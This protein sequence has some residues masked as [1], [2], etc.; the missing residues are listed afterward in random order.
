M[1]KSKL[2]KE[3]LLSTLVT[4]FGQAKSIVFASQDGLTV[5]ASQDLRKKAKAEGVEMMAVKKTILQMALNK[6]G[7]TGADISAMSG[8]LAVAVSDKDEVAPAKVIK[9][10]AKTNEKVA[11]RGGFMNGAVL[12]LVEVQKI[13]DLPSKQELLAK[14]VGSLNAPVAGF[15][16]VLAGNLRGLVTVLGAIKNNK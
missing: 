3:E 9:D 1:P 8:S 15:V 4:R 16:N 11:L 5:S 6:S 12:S 13:A 7:L 2:Q 10:F 14:L